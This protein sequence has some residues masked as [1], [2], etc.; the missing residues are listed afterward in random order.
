MPF[1]LILPLL[2]G[3]AGAALSPGGARKLPA[4]MIEDV[5]VG[6]DGS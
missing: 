3:E 6:V 5:G 4:G 2:V 1:A